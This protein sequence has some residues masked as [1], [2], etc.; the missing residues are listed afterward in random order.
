MDELKP[1]N[2]L[3]ALFCVCVC[4]CV[5]DISIAATLVFD[6]NINAVGGGLSATRSVAWEMKSDV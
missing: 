6:R 5:C 3:L 2:M 4:V 1:L